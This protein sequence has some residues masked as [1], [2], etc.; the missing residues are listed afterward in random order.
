[1][2]ARQYLEQVIKIDKV[3]KNKLIEREQWHY[4]AMG[5]GGSSSE[6]DRVQ[7]S[8]SKQKMADAVVRVVEIEE[9]ID[10]YVKKLADIK[11]DVIKT[12][13]QLDAASYDILHIRY[14]QGKDLLEISEMYGKPLPSIKR[15][16]GKAL[17]KLQA[18]L[19]E[20]NKHA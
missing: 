11:E 18:I 13:E 19:D 9:E 10:K 20:R 16:Q 5:T 2:E 14:I 8:G 17:K 15:K 1:M 3:I 4:I 12:I 7:S 6:C